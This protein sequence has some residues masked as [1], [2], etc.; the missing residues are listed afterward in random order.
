MKDN[1][2]NIYKIISFI[3]KLLMGILTFLCMLVVFSVMVI[4]SIK[5]A[6]EGFLNEKELQNMINNIDIMNILINTNEFDEINFI[7]DNFIDSGIDEETIDAFITSTPINNYVKESLNKQI[8]NILNGKDERV[9]TKDS[10][11]NFLELNMSL[12]VEE[13]Q[14]KNIP[15]SEKLTKENQEKILN[16]IKLKLPK[17]EEKILSIGDR[18]NS[19]LNLNYNINIKNIIYIIKLF[20]INII[21]FL[22]ILL[23]ILYVMGI[24]ITRKSFIKSL[25]WIGLTFISSGVMIYVVNKLLIK[26][27][28]NIELLPNILI[29]FIKTTFL[30][31]ISILKDYATLFILFGILFILI[32]LIIYLIKKYKRENN[33]R[34]KKY[35]KKLSFNK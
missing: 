4:F 6:S 12:I 18:L 7:K 13:L 27:Q 25:K 17:I 5:K 10:I 19:L 24:V 16:K 29:D 30:N 35:F 21:D 34:I 15:K 2:K 32:E 3:K 33:N 28:S 11:Y 22:L 9:F 8:D 1:K 14:E 26:L 31:I 23:F 20:Y